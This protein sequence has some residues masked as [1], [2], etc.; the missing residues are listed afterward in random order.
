MAPKLS[1]L[2]RGANE[3]NSRSTGNN[4]FRDTQI[5]LM[6]CVFDPFDQALGVGSPMT[7]F[8]FGLGNRVVDDLN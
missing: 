1:N 6:H 8:Y 7:T 3:Q 4:G 2:N 5:V